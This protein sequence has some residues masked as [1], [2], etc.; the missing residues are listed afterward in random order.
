MEPVRAEGFAGSGDG[1]QV[2]S[3]ACSE[4]AEA[5]T[6]Q[7]RDVLVSAVSATALQ[8]LPLREA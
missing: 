1:S 2:G 7:Q 5:Q 4:E 8:L 3:G 6:Q